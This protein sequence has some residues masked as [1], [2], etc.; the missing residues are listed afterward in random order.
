MEQTNL[1]QVMEVIG[2]AVFDYLPVEDSVNNDVRKNINTFLQCSL[3]GYVLIPWPE[4][5]S[6]M[7]EEWFEEEAVL[8]LGVEDKFGSSAYFI[9]IHR[10]VNS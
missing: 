5:Q 10:I 1:E 3:D 8:A 9:P 7:E 4:S 2:Q 6:Y